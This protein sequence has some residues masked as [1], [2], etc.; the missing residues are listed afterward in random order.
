[1]N[2]GIWNKEIINFIE[3][4]CEC[5]R[6]LPLPYDILK[7]ASTVCECGNDNH[8]YYEYGDDYE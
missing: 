5:G 7:G 8:I 3:G 1:M 2:T 6:N 4:K